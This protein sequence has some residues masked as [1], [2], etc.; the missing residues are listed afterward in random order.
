MNYQKLK[1]ILQKTPCPNCGMN[2]S[3]II[4]YNKFGCSNCY[5]YFADYSKAILGKKNYL[6]NNYG[7]IPKNPKSTQNIINILNTKI[8]QAIKIEDYESAAK[9]RDEIKE[10]TLK[11]NN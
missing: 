3:D 5:D 8:H 7:K 4:Y 1:Q 2:I 11:L 10:L 6:N 9:Y